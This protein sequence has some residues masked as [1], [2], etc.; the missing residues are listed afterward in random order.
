MPDNEKICVYC[1]SKE[2]RTLHPG[3][4]RLHGLEGKFSVDSCAA[5][6]LISVHPRLTLA[7]VD[8]YYP[9]NYVSYPTAIEDEKSWLK[10]M[11]RTYGREKRCHAVMKRCGNT[12]RILDIG[13]ATGIF[14]H[15]MKQHGWECY[16]IE[17]SAFAAQYAHERFQL[18]VFQGYLEESSF[19]EASFDVVSMWDVL[20]HVA[21][22]ASTLAQI[23]RLLKPDG[24]LVLTMPNADAWER[25]IF[26][27]N[28]VG[29]DVPRHFNIFTP[30]TI[31]NQ[32][33][34]SNFA[35]REI[36]SFTGRHGALVLSVQFCL[37]DKNIPGWLKTGLIK[38][39]QSLVMR[40]FTYPFY[41]VADRLNRS[42]IMTIFAQRIN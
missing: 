21:D 25:H 1:G 2:F 19:P 9:T 5:C 10:R 33:N 17:P 16:G 34:P 42:S 27:E 37:A 39:M 36:V 24:W 15:G 13:C 22:P 12:G 8:K 7:E 18:N 29:W 35:V 4:D 28:W 26:G 40:A 20:E 32:L 6:G 31:T 23:A 30:K 14:L 11:D 41:I 3:R 38:V